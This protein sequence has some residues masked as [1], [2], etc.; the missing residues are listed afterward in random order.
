M[1]IRPGT[2]LILDSV[3]FILFVVVA[4]SGLILFLAPSGGYNGARG[5]STPESLLSLRRQGLK[6]VHN[7]VGLAL[8]GLVALHVILHL[9]WVTCQFKRLFKKPVRSAAAT[10][11]RP[12]VSRQV[13]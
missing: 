8:A 9:P 1:K 11:D 13:G 12:P 7:W 4:V 10:A 6:T 3:I 2:H 5:L